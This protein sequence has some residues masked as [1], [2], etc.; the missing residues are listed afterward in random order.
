MNYS[1]RF[2]IPEGNKVKLKDFDPGFTD[3]HEN[4]KSALAKIEKLQQRMD[5]LQFKLYAEQNR[6]LLICLQSTDAGGKDG[7]VR[8][9]IGSM[10]PQG[11]RVVS[12]KEPSKEELS[13]DFLWRIEHQAPKRGEV[14]IFNRSHYEDVLI[15]RV[16][17]LVPKKVWSQ[18]YEQIN[19]FEQRLVANDTHIL[20]FFLHISK[21]EQLQRFKQRLDDPARYWKISEADY[22]ERE[23]WKDY[24][25]AYEEVLSK[26]STDIAPWF[27]IPSDHKWFRNLAVSQ[28]IVETM[29][30]L[31]IK[32]PKPTV[33]IE[34]IRGKYHKAANG[35]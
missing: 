35:E 10:N 7:V 13:H 27:V 22:Q 25:S 20:K 6:S 26:C 28:I 33:D 34:A 17:D 21:E 30:N 23:Y 11:C 16:H 31:D 2:R 4:K 15:V 12:F 29:E 1:K 8:N 5:E 18:R 32:L 3:G 19:A 24:E 9:V 14:V